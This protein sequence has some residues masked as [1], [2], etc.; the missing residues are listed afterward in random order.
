V[1]RWRARCCVRSRPGRRG[2]ARWSRGRNCLRRGSNGIGSRHRPDWGRSP[3]PLRRPGLLRSRGEDG[4]VWE[5]LEE[6][7]WQIHPQWVCA[8]RKW[9]TPVRED[10]R[11]RVPAWDEQKED[12][13]GR[14][15]GGEA[16]LCSE[17]ALVTHRVGR[18]GIDR[19]GGRW[20]SPS[21]LYSDSAVITLYITIYIWSA[22]QVHTGRRQLPEYHHRC[23]T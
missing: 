17:E 22:W 21:A 15:V 7:D 23:F 1:V 3:S 19:R 16:S 18:G 9:S 5:K 20:R 10:C 6:G 4:V 14:V 11:G 8:G 13:E 12:Q 2:E